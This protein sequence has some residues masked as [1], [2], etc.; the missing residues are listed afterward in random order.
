[1]IIGYVPKANP[2]YDLFHKV[3]FI[4]YTTLF[5]TTHNWY[6]RSNFKSNMFGKIFPRAPLSLL[7]F[8]IEKKSVPEELVYDLI[9]DEIHSTFLSWECF[10]VRINITRHLPKSLSLRI[11]DRRFEKIKKYHAQLRLNRTVERR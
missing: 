8:H 7:M 2:R 1:M 5:Y 4:I 11:W 9:W 10:L 6:V 3:L